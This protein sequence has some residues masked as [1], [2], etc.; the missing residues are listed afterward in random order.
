[1]APKIGRVGFLSRPSEVVLL[2]LAFLAANLLLLTRLELRLTAN[3]GHQDTG[4]QGC[5]VEEEVRLHLI[6]E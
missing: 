2:L 1:M 4:V 3:T 6:K 5:A